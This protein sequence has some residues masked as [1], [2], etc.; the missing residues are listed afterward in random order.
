M[1]NFEFNL[2]ELS[3]EDKLNINGGADGDFA[4]ALGRG[5]TRGIVN[6]VCPPYGLYL[7]AKDFGF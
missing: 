4:Y 1:K 3:V 7:L 2:Q 6:V 5:L